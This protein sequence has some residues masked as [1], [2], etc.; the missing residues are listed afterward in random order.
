MSPNLGA[1]RTDDTALRR[2]LWR[3]EYGHLSGRRV[4]RLLR[5]A[6][7]RATRD[8][9]SLEPGVPAARRTDPALL[10]ERD[11]FRAR[12]D[13]A[14]RREHFRAALD[15]LLRGRRTLA[16]M[17]ALVGAASRIEG[18]EAA[19]RALHELVRVPRLRALPCIQAPAELLAAA[20]TR[21]AGRRYAQ[22]AYLADASLAEASPL[23]RRER[24]PG[25]SARA[26]EARIGEV[27]SLCAETRALAG[28]DEADPLEDGSLDAIEALAGDGFVALAER[29][30]SELEF[31]LEARARLHRELRR[32]GPDDDVLRSVA[33]AGPDAWASATA[34][35]WLSRVEAGVRRVAS[36]RSR[37]D[38]AGAL[39]DAGRPG[40][41]EP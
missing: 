29:L 24:T 22:A 26:L 37:L 19:T 5:A 41:P 13:D 28:T 4:K 16:S 20:R 9:D 17:R 15:E 40:G 12:A 14:I 27:R 38:R 30:A 35:L 1:A 21:M 11:A 6:Y 25:P 31:S 23:E 34:T 10:A 33:A 7:L 39:L 8:F 18:A 3:F 32:S 36:Q 2:A